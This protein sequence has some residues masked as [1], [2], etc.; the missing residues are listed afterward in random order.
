MATRYVITKDGARVAGPFKSK[1]RARN[2]ADRLDNACGAYRH[3]VHGLCAQC[4]A[5]I[6]TYETL[7][8]NHKETP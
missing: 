7:C 6:P 3:T 1:A 2:K 5:T 4:E 8:E